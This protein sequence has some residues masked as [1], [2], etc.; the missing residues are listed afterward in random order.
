MMRAPFEVHG[1]PPLPVVATA[2]HAGHDLRADV[3]DLMALDEATRRREEDPFT[4]VVARGFDAHVVVH[5]SRFEVDLNR[6]R[7]GAVYLRP[8][9][10]WGLRVWSSELPADVVERSRELHDSFYRSMARLLDPLAAQGPFVV[11]DVHS[12]NHRRSG[13]GA[14]PAPPA[15]NP[16]VNV[17]TGSLDR[18]RFGPVVDRFIAALDGVECGAGPLDVRENVRFE[19]AHLARWVHE[20]YP[21]T[22]CTL[23]LE[24]KKTFMDEWTDEVDHAHLG[25]LRDAIVAAVPS[26]LAGLDEVAD[27]GVTTS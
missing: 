5:R 6:S 2:I 13:P 15:G 9:E 24:L 19:G 18:R 22:G 10:S 25:Q 14:A 4:D 11:L 26:V 23:A 27:R 17:G 12:Y 21:G 20:R 1:T 8:D 3:Q 16:D 7:D